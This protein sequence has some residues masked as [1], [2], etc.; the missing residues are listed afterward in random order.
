MLRA[1]DLF[2]GCGGFTHGAKAAGLDVR[3]AANHWPLAVDVHAA[4]HPETEH[5]CQ[6][7]AQADF[8]AVP[9]HDVLLASPAC[10][11]HSIAR[12]VD[13]PHHDV[14]R[15][16]A[17]AVIAAVEANEPEV[18]VVENVAGFRDRWKLFDV[19][20]SALEAYGYHLTVDVLDAADCGVPQNRERVFVVGRRDRAVE[21][22]HGSAEHVPARSFLD[23]ESGN[24]SRVDRPGRADRTLRQWRAGVE[25]FGDEPFLAPYYGKGSGLIGRSIDRPIGTVT[26]RDR[27]ALMRGDEMRMLTRDE[28]RRAMGF[29]A[30]YGFEALSKKKAVHLLGN[31]VPP[32]LAEHVV[33]QA[34]AGL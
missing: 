15:A 20:L 1:I 29:P 31:A 26:T 27:W 25:E 17:W 6:D 12:G 32:A 3:W 18:V 23:V 28:Y 9:E 5:E 10:Q 11:G 14:T 22:E 19:W 4:A 13:R 24:W 8:T 2:A 16:T 7:L 21:I 33:R 30:G 34:V